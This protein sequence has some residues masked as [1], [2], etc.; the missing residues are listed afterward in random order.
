M[1]RDVCSK[2]TSGEG[3]TEGGNVSPVEAM[4]D[5]MAD[6]VAVWLERERLAA[7]R[8]GLGGGAEEGEMAR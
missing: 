5:A 3:K 2:G 8:T 6:A 4:M 1:A 7:G